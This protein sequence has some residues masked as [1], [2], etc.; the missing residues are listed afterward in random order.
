[1]P[2]HLCSRLGIRMSTYVRQAYLLPLALCAPMAAVLWFL[3]RWFVPHSYLQLIPQL[4]AAGVVYGLCLGWA[5]LT[6][7]ALKVEGLPAPSI[8]QRGVGRDGDEG[9]QLGI[10]LFNAAETHFRQLHGRDLFAVHQFSCFGES[11]RRETC[12]VGNRLSFASG[13]TRADCDSRNQ[14]P[15][16]SGQSCFHKQ[17]ARQMRNSHAALLCAKPRR[18]GESVASARVPLLAYDI[19]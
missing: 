7:R 19:S 5:H 12:I 9:V 2:Y 14:C 6:D 10:E 4:L 17:P 11:E 8:D 18:H 16:R 1:M 15:R 13:W 3:Q